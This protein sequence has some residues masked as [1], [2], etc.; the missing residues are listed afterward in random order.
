MNHYPNFATLNGTALRYSGEG[1]YWRDA[2]RWS[3]NSKWI[4]GKLVC[5]YEEHPYDSPYF[6][7]P[8]MA[9]A[10]GQEL[11]KCTL[12]EWKKDNDGYLPK[13]INLIQRIKL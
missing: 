1:K 9:Y 12:K 2:G 5:S 11:K 6:T 8:E 10:D 4:D 7:D 13:E 3:V